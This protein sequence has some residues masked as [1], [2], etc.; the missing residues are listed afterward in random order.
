MDVCAITVAHVTGLTQRKRV[1]GRRTNLRGGGT[2]AAPLWA[3][4]RGLIVLLGLAAV[5]IAAA[6]IQV[7]AWL[8]GPMFLALM[9][10][11]CVSPLQGWL[12]RHGFPRWVG[13]LV[14]VLV[15]Y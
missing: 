6:G 3:L 12:R 9:I 11:I 13:T 15:V 5:V 7:M 2:R 14:L 8:V 1:A 10:V 4:P